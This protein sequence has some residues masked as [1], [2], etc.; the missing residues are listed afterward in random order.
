VLAAE[1]AGHVTVVNPFGTVLSQNKLS[2][3]LMWEAQQHFSPLARRWIRRYIPQT[4]RLTRM[5]QAEL[6][7]HRQDWVLKSVYGC[8]GEETI[9][10]PFVSPETW[11]EAVTT[12]L[13]PLWVGQRFFHA[14]PEPQG[15]LCNYGVYLVGGKSAGFFARLAPATTAVDAITAPIFIATRKGSR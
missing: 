11:H 8:E 6:L 2:L 7:A 9:C 13:P 3:A 5:C 14:A 4:Y 12:A 1:Y 10:G 15:V